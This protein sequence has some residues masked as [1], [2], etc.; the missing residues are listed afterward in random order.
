MWALVIVGLALALLKQLLWAVVPTVVVSEGAISVVT[1][2]DALIGYQERLLTAPGDGT[3]EFLVAQGQRVRRGTRLVRLQLQTGSKAGQR[4]V[5]A[6]ETTLE[7]VQ[8][9]VSEYEAAL[10]AMRRVLARG[11]A[12]TA[13]AI[14]DAQHI[15]NQWHA[16]VERLAGL[17][18]TPTSPNGAAPAVDD[19]CGTELNL[20]APVGGTT[21]FENG[22]R[23]H[24]LGLHHRYRSPDRFHPQWRSRH[25]G[26]GGRRQQ[27]VLARSARLA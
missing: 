13:A 24:H 21:I 8:Q 20:R 10:S 2:A 25:I 22:T 7:Q 4:L 11:A 16:A 1:K 12:P 23:R 5:T 14:A 19:W 26:T 9:A 18:G 6:I 15:C 27:V 3:L 17:S